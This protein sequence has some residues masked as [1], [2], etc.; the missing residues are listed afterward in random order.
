MLDYRVT[1][2][3][4]A[5]TFD[6]L[7]YSAYHAILVMIGHNTALLILWAADALIT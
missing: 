1:N 6:A 5:T 7:L 4:M 3:G 2:N